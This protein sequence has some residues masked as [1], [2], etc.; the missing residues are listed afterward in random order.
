MAQQ[1]AQQLLAGTANITLGQSLKAHQLAHRLVRLVRYPDLGQM[2]GAKVLRQAHRIPAVV[3]HPV[4]CLARNKGGR[5][6]IAAVPQAGQQTLH[7]IAARPRLVAKVKRGIVRL[8]LLAKPAQSIRR[9]RNR[10]VVATRLARALEHRRHRDRLLV[11]IQPNK[12]DI[13]GHGSSP[14]RV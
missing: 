12:Q 11:D 9:I 2:P 6:H 4:A 10:A 14:L 5:H 1:K 7:P 3:L 8:Q 13:A